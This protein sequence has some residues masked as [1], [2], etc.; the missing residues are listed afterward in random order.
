ME[1][2]CDN[3]GDVHIFKP[4]IFKPRRRNITENIIEVFVRCPECGAE[5]Y[6]FYKNKR[7]REVMKEN[8]RLQKKLASK[9]GLKAQNTILKKIR[10]NKDKIKHEQERINKELEKND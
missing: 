5:I 2:K 4:S 10:Q 7:V 8:S 3:C 1:V 6:S 9:K